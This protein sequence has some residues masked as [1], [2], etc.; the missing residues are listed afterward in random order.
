M[1][2]TKEMLPLFALGP[3]GAI[4]LKPVL[5]LIFEQLLEAGFREFCFI[6]GRGRGR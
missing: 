1:P 5:H 4:S 2:A 6:V 3:N